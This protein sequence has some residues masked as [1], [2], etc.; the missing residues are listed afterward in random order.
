[1]KFFLNHKKFFIVTFL[2]L[3][4][5]FP[6]F[7]QCDFSGSISVSASGF[8]SG[9]G[10]TQEYI[11]VN[12]VSD[13]ILAINTTGIFSSLA[14]GNYRIYAINYLG[15][16]PTEIAVSS[17][18]ANFVA[19]VS[20]YCVDYIGPYSGSAVTFCE[21]I[22]LG[23]DLTVS[24]SGY[25]S[26][27]NYVQKYVVVNSSGNIV[28]TNTSGTF[29]GLAVG[30]Y[31][32]YA[33]NTDDATVKTEIDDLGAWSDISSASGCLDILGLKYVNVAAG[34][35]ATFTVIENC[36]SNE[37]NIEVDVS[38]LG[39]S[40]SVNII[41][42][43][44]TTYESAVG[45]G[46]YTLTGFASGSTQTIVVEDA[47]NSSCNDSESGLTFTCSSADIQICTGTN[48]VVSTSGFEAGGGFEQKYIVVNS[49]G[50]IVATNTTG[51]FSGLT[52]GEYDV[53]AVNT[54]NATL[55]TEIED[56]GAWS[57]VSSSSECFDMLG[58]KTLDVQDCLILPI[59]LLFFNCSLNNKIV[60]ISW[61]TTTEINNDFFTVERSK[62]GID[63][64]FLIKSMG[65]G[66]SNT[67]IHY[68]EVDENPY[69]GTS[70]Y[71]LIQTD[72]SGLHSTSNIVSVNLEHNSENLGLDISNV[73]LYPN[74]VNDMLNLK[75]NF[76]SDYGNVR[77]LIFDVYGK[78]LSEQKT[79]SLFGVNENNINTSN[80]AGG[81]Y[82]IKLISKNQLVVKR[83]VKQ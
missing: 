32:V 82:F 40:S 73:E 38:S 45:T 57:D 69:S 16:R 80:F 72:Y 78:A 67:E 62:N 27:G 70:Y 10:Y 26:G 52:S 12:D 28:A 3:A 7:S 74:P 58:P 20:S 68:S 4:F 54:D 81:V 76:N 21:Q 83:F 41:D 63:F 50:N 60:E 47:S 29:S 79:T 15:S 59:S 8:E 36:G 14:D 9:L 42:D 39:I 18:W 23:T 31:T 33:V 64:E 43:T 66:N 75:Y 51:T 2:L 30:D 77:I 19:N 65:A 11:L 48:L 61:V 49:S 44:P 17:D 34:P 6:S 25:T 1:M 55:Q 56:L 13:E 46:T 5:Y 24:T 35:S 71:R 53:Y 37:F 22:C